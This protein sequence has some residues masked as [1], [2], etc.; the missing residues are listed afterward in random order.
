MKWPAIAG[1]VMIASLFAGACRESGSDS[2]ETRPLPPELEQMLAEI[3]GLRGLDPPSA[4]EAGTVSRLDV[5]AL[6]DRELTD[7]DRRWFTRTT[8]LYRLLGHLGPDEDYLSVFRDFGAGA[9]VGLYSPVSNRL[10]VVQGE[11]PIDLDAMSPP[12]RSALAHELVHAIQD[13]HFALDELSLRT[14][15]DLDWSMAA[16]AVIEGDAV[17]HQG[18]WDARQ[19]ALPGGTRLFLGT[20]GAGGST[21]PSIE[22]ELRFPYTT[23]AEWVNIVRSEEGTAAIDHYLAGEPISTAHILHPELRKTGWQ[24]ERVVLPELGAALGEGWSRESGGTFGEFHLRNY[25]QLGLPALPSVQA[26]SGWRGDRYDVYV[27]ADSAVAVFRVRFA[28]AVEA[29]EFAAAQRDMLAPAGA[30]APPGGRFVAE[31]RDGRTTIQLSS[32]DAS[33]VL[34]VVGSTRE[35]AELAAR[36]VVNA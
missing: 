35:A 28:D 9:I 31:L 29:E 20:H 17:T 8:T 4:L 14:A 33:E 7:A 10:W 15:A 11:P 22:R 12:E 16:T 6:L 19:L 36:A 18:L 26:A 25:L 2:F 3:A 5:P 23:G 1:L 24:P 30:E 13:Y 34:F 21:P 27:R 32:P